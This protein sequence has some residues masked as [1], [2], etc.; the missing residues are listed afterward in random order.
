MESHSGRRKAKEN[1]WIKKRMYTY[2]KESLVEVIKRYCEVLSSRADELVGDIKG[3]RS[4]TFT[5]P[6]TMDEV[7]HIK[8]EK[9]FIDTNAIGAIR[10]I[11]VP[12]EEQ[13]DG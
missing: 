1:G 7:P 10:I 4:I 8:V 12:E 2:T 5:M 9:N 3:M 11:E 6:V 13:G